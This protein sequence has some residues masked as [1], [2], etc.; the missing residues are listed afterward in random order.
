MWVL[1]LVFIALVNPLD[2]AAQVTSSDI[3]TTYQLTQEVPPG[4]IICLTETSLGVC[5][6]AYDPAMFG[7]TTET[8]TGV[9]AEIEPQQNSS[10]VVKSG[11]TVLRVTNSGGEIRAGDLI[12]SSAT[13]GVG[14]RASRNGFIIGRALEGFNNSEEGTILVAVH[15][16]Q[17]T[18]FSDVRSNLLELLRQGLAAPI[19][20]PLAFLRY[21]LSAFVLVTAFILGFIYFG[22]MARTSVEAVGRN[23]L[24][25]RT[26][27][28]NIVLNLIF[29]FIIFSIGFALAYL[30]LVL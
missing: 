28:F 10:M 13:P 16:Q 25:S 23:P 29:M 1:L 26:I 24:A 3:A 7:V 11:N 17:T 30:I 19:L 22:K 4:S 15:I 8:P 6:F 14:Q 27:Q 9:F 2:I 18:A 21:I 5:S 20:T 12:T